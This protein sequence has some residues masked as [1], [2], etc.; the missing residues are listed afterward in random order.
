[1]DLI[2]PRTRTSILPELKDERNGIGV[3]AADGVVEH[4]AATASEKNG[5]IGQRRVPYG[6]VVHLDRARPTR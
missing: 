6:V 5:I 3:V 4:D 2:Q 1:M